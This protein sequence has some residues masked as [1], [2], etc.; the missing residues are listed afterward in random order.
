MTDLLGT[1]HNVSLHS[2]SEGR[3][4][5]DISIRT[6]MD[7]VVNRAPTVLESEVPANDAARNSNAT[8]YWKH[9]TASHVF[10]KT[11]SP[12]ITEAE[13]PYNIKTYASIGH[14]TDHE[15]FKAT[16]PSSRHRVSHNVELL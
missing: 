7:L 5:M 4:A 14:H 8:A 13:N 2:T 11:R 1:E 6:T 10:L 9:D 15:D 16:N 12:E 3:D